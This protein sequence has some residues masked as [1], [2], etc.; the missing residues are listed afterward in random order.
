[1]KIALVVGHKKE[2]PGACN[3]TNNICEWAFNDKL[4]HDIAVI[5]DDRCEI[6]I[7]YRDRYKDLPEKINALNPNFVICLHCNAFNTKV[8]GT[9]VLY[10][11]K[12]K[13]GK[14]MA[15]IFQNEIVKA[16]GLRNRGIKGKSSEEKGGY[17]LRETKAPCIITE[18]FFLDN[19]N[20]YRK[21]ID[22][23]PELIRACNE[24]IYEVI[25]TF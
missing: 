15:T 2:K 20:D 11:Y 23:Y 21:V 5:T 13:R 10:Y 14:K 7:V 8:S 18:P 16:L 3:K 1:M 17:V 12:S 25:D 24:S 19:D 9:S 4:A 22:H 6:E